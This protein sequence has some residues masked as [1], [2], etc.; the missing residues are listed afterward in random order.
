MIYEMLNREMIFPNLEADRFEDV[1]RKLGGAATKAGYAKDTYA[2]ALVEREKE[3][4]TALDVEGYGVA[5]PHTPVD[6][7]LGTVIPVA[8]LKEPVE[9]IQMGSDDE[10]IGVRII[11][12]LTL[13]GKPGE[14]DHLDQLQR[15]LAIIQDT[16]V[17]DQ[18]LAAKNADEIM[19]I[20]KEKENSL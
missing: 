19:N 14:H 20:I 10:T 9:F 2:D 6:H 13:A 12:M 8:I 5:I 16:G 7:V 18:L 3:Y 1:L 15:V 11:F 17:L 4:P